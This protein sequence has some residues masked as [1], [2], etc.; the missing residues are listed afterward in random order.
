MEISES[1]QSSGAA[2]VGTS[3]AMFNLLIPIS[4]IALAISVLTLIWR[5][6]FKT[7]GGVA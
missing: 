2:I 5:I 7:V 4:I 1:L 3:Q 6:I